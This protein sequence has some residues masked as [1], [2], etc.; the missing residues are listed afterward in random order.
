MSSARHPLQPTITKSLKSD[1]SKYVPS[2][3]KTKK[4]RKMKKITPSNILHIYDKFIISDYDNSK[5]IENKKTIS[6]EDSEAVLLVKS[7]KI[8]DTK[9]GQQLVKLIKPLQNNPYNY[10]DPKFVDVE[11]QLSVEQRFYILNFKPPEKP[12]LQELIC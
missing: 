8:I 10:R 4:K 3:S 9:Y 11:P 1:K 6:K 5:F 7:S 12:K 2:K